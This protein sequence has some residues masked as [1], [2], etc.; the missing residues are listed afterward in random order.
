MSYCRFASDGSDVYV[1]GSTFEGEPCWVC[2][3]TPDPFMTL[4]RQVM[5]N[6]LAYH[7]GQGDKVPDHAF[8][9]LHKEIKIEKGE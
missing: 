9:R 7:R 8:E 2:H 3:C 6:H 4:S 1:I 5:V